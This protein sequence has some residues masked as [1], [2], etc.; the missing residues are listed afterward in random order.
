MAIIDEIVR[1]A[2]ARLSG[3]HGV[4]ISEEAV[5]LAKQPVHQDAPLAHP[6]AALSRLRRAAA[7]AE[8]RGEPAVTAEALVADGVATRRTE[9]VKDDL[10][11]ALSASIVGQDDAVETVAERLVVTARGLDL[12]PHR[13][14]GVFLFL[15]PT[16]VGKTAMAQALAAELFAPEAFIRLDMSEYNEPQSVNRLTGPPPGYV[17]YTEP[18]T[19]LTTR[20]RA[21]GPCVILLDEIEK[22]DP[23]VWNAFL[24]VFDAGRLT[25]SR[26]LV[27]N[28]ADTIIVLTSNVGADRYHKK[29]LGF[30]ANDGSVGDRA[31]AA[32]K[33]RMPPE[34]VNRLDSVVVFN[35]LAQ[36]DIAAIADLELTQMAPQWRE[37]GYDV[38]WDHKVLEFLACTG[39][40]PE[41]GARHVHRV[42]ESRLVSTLMAAGPGRW[43]ATVQDG[44]IR[45]MPIPADAP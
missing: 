17:G 28:F 9:V 41:Y 3:R 15:G 42:M 23:E 13:P 22:A 35:E 4:D 44:V 16:G 8:A 10:V 5:V 45:W 19:W 7:L 24:A 33:D 25:D 36:S 18:R 12:R 1:E 43:A 38:S 26:G 14:D 29:A 40:E 20:V 27:T 6:G 30:A 37:R 11:A 39:Y 34:L 2:A 21:L 31:R 32:L